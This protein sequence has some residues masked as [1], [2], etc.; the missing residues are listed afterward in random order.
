MA[1]ERSASRQKVKKS[2][3]WVLGVLALWSIVS[4]VVIVVWATSPELKGSASCRAELQEVTEKLEGAK[5]VWTKNK[6]ALEELLA[7]ERQRQEQRRAEAALLLRR[8]SAINRTREECRED[9]VRL[10]PPP[11]TPSP[12]PAAPA[13]VSRRSAHPHDLRLA[14]IAKTLT[15][16]S[17]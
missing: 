15:H 1:T 7:A 9:Q 12:R 11:P 10:R 6:V 14:R 5:V 3:L 17:A 8:L 2:L 4:L 16:L 13:S